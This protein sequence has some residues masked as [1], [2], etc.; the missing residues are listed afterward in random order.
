MKKYLLILSLFVV[1]QISAQ[2]SHVKIEPV[3]FSK[4]NVTDAFWKPKMDLVATKT[5]AACIYQTE[6]KTGRI[7]NFEKVARNRGE[8]HE[9]IFYD[10][11]D[12]YK[13][14]EA[15]AYSIKTN[16]DKTL[17]AKADEWI[18][19]IASAQLQDGYLNTFY[20]LT[21]LDKRWSDMSMHED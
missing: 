2:S 19:K 1:V 8:K 20:T 5:L 15:M 11:S 21:G 3:N 14:I 12:V 9:G 17:E 4:V 13:A 7:R 18:D 16:K 6:E 10:D